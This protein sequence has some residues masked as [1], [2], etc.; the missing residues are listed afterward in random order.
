MAPHSMTCF[1][2]TYRCTLARARSHTHTQTH[3][4]SR[5]LTFFRDFRCSKPW[6]FH[7]HF[8]KGP[9][10][11]FGEICLRFQP[12]PKSEK[13]LCIVSHIISTGARI[14][15]HYF[16]ATHTL[17]FLRL[18][19]ETLRTFLA[20][21]AEKKPLLAAREPPRKFP[22]TQNRGGSPLGAPRQTTPYSGKI[23]F[24][25]PKG[26]GHGYKKDVIVVI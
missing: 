3:H 23:Q 11:V 22:A 25:A 14:M 21:G 24:F 2:A 13:I 18:V 9:N 15:M 10:F 6:C 17:R 8:F 12:K 26:C 5:C 19:S 20:G 7:C 1:I 4:F 16:S